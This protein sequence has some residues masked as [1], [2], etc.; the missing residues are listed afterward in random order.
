[1]VIERIHTE[2]MTSINI[3]FESDYSY[4]GNASNMVKSGLE[5]AIDFFR[6][7]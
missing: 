6:K 5:S 2:S 7:L 4:F 3:V 1:M